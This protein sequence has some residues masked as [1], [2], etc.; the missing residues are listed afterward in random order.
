[1]TMKRNKLALIALLAALSS[2]GVCSANTLPEAQIKSIK[3]TVDGVPVPELAPK[4]AEIVKKASAKDR[5]DVAVTVVRLIVTEKPTLARDVVVAVVKVAPEVSSAV[6]RVAA[7]LC[8]EQAMVIAQDAAALA[9]AQAKE[10]AAAVAKCAPESALRITKAV[11]VTNPDNAPKIIEAVILAVP[12]SKAAIE[13]DVTLGIVNVLARSTRS[14]ASTFSSRVVTSIPRVNELPPSPIPVSTKEERSTSLRTAVSD[15][16]SFEALVPTVDKAQISAAAVASIKAINTI[17]KDTTFTKAE[18]ESL[19]LSVSGTTK[20]IIADPDVPASAK[21]D[22]A[23][24]AAD[25]MRAI[26][27]DTD[28]DKEAK[29]IFVDYVSQKVQQ[30]STSSTTGLALG[31][32]IK[33]VAGEIQKVIQAVQNITPAAAQNALAGVEQNVENIKQK[34]SSPTP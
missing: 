30:L 25:A 21:G 5:E 9:P 13:K 15:I 19:V 33:A 32:S 31:E 26:V 17:S 34:Y 22:A 24:S 4:A 1:M 8:P 27:S 20:T 28:T 10:I 29:K 3:K 2:F 18:R 16:V 6:T 11:V 14:N 23:K 12:S 7:E